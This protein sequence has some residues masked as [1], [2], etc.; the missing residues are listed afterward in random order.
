MR[1]S[2]FFVK[3]PIAGQRASDRS[4]HAEPRVGGLPAVQTQLAAGGDGH[5]APGPQIS[6]HAQPGGDEHDVLARHQ[7][8]VHHAREAGPQRPQALREPPE[9]QDRA[10]PAAHRLPKPRGGDRGES[11]IRAGWL[12][13]CLAGWLTE[14]LDDWLAGWLPGWLVGYHPQNSGTVF[15][16]EYKVETLCS[17]TKVRV[18]ILGTQCLNTAPF[19]AGSRALVLGHQ[20]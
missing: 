4:A 16:L 6:D 2:S 9:R 8:V 13:C 14:W 5:G 15:V 18:Y 20:V 17:G 1:A 19:C 7:R 3:G 11:V 10:G 12:L